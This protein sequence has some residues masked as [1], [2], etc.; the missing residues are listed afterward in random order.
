[1]YSRERRLVSNCAKGSTKWGGTRTPI[2]S[3]MERHESKITAMPVVSGEE[4]RKVSFAYRFWH[5]LRASCFTGVF[6]GRAK[7]VPVYV[8]NREW[9]SD[10]FHQMPIAL[11]NVEISEV[12]RRSSA[13][14]RERRSNT[15]S[16]IWHSLL[17]GFSL[18]HSYQ[19]AT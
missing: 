11:L 8:L 3:I 12:M 14:E 2:S 17:A 7:C 16:P 13:W 18:Q 19:P 1:M 4:T 9:D 6:M 10:S 5:R 15:A